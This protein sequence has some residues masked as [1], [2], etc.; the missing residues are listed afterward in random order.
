MCLCL[1]ANDDEKARKYVEIRKNNDKK[2][3]EKLENDM[4]KF[5]EL[6]GEVR[7]NRNTENTNN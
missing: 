1:Y 2:A 3:I 4:K 7:E 5:S 6:F